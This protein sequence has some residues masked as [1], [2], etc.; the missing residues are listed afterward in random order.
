MEADDLFEHFIS[1]GEAEY[2]SNMGVCE[3]CGKRKKVCSTSFYSQY[4]KDCIGL[5][6]HE[7]K[8]AIKSIG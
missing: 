7:S 3:F 2:K 6:V 5:V 4:C 1:L 8:Q